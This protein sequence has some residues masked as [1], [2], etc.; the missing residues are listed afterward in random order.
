[1]LMF[2]NFDGNGLRR[3][4]FKVGNIIWEVFE[5]EGCF[6]F[7]CCIWFLQMICNFIL[8]EVFKSEEVLS[9]IVMMSS[10]DE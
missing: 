2:V 4:F 3:I 7:R 10:S 9:Q 6:F 8:V 5:V 1:M